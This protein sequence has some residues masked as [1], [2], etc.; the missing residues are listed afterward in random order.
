MDTPRDE[1]DI[2]GDEEPS[3]EEEFEALMEAAS[4]Q[5]AEGVSVPTEDDTDAEPAVAPAPEPARTDRAAP[6][7]VPTDAARPS[8]EAD[9]DEGQ[10]D[11]STGDVPAASEPHDEPLAD[12][13]LDKADTEAREVQDRAAAAARA[14]ARAEESAALAAT[15]AAAAKSAPAANPA[16]ARAP[17]VEPEPV[18]AVNDLVRLLALALAVA[19]LSVTAFAFIKLRER[20][21]PPPNLLPMPAEPNPLGM[22]PGGPGLPASVVVADPGDVAPAPDDTADQTIPDTQVAV[23]PDVD[24]TPEPTVEPPADVV[25]APTPS[26]EPTVEPEPAPPGPVV[27]AMED[28]GGPDAVTPVGPPD[29]GEPEVVEF[30]PTGQRVQVASAI[31]QLRAQ[32]GAT[33]APPAEPLQAVDLSAVQRRSLEAALATADREFV[34]ALIEDAAGLPARIGNAEWARLRQTPGYYR[35]LQS[36]YDYVLTT[37][38]KVRLFAGHSVDAQGETPPST[39]EFLRGL[40]LPPTDL[41]RVRDELWDANSENITRIVRSTL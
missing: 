9:P 3:E 34:R 13:S 5:A 26:V 6:A 37:N 23:A 40:E 41:A 20:P 21:E 32:R 4:E 8:A 39:P 36:L 30:Q 2:P 33:T 10:A 7:N 29:D 27:V 12:G 19:G 25:A 24:P 35:T 15:A 38:D 11:G 18:S 1:E 22:G 31:D 28:S 16:A 17:V 14:E